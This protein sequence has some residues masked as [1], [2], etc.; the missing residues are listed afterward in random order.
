EMCALRDSL[1]NF[2]SMNAQVVGISVDSPF[3]NKGFAG[4]NNLSFPLLSDYTRTVSKQY[5]GLYSDFGGLAGYTAAKRSVFILDKS[6]VIRHVWISENPGA[7]P[8]Y[9][10]ISKDLASLK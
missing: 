7:E 1:S 2:E 3:A 10:Q 4:Q 6:G 5:C 9:A 8:D